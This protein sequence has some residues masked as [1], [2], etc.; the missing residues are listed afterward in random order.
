MEAAWQL[1]RRS[2]YW[3]TIYETLKRRLRAKRAIVAVARR[4]LGVMTAILK[5]G[6]RYQPAHAT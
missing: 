3:K 4:L 1:V 5:S 2:A 6:R